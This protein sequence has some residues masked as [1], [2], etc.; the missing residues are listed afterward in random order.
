[1]KIKK[2]AVKIILILIPILCILLPSEVS[3]MS[4]EEAGTY[5]AR[6]A[7]N[8]YND[9]GELVNYEVDYTKR[10]YC[11]NTGKPWEATGTY[12]IDCVGFVALVIKQSIHLQSDDGTVENGGNGYVVPTQWASDTQFEVV[13][14][15]KPGDI[16]AN[17]HHVMIYVGGG[18]IV[19]CDGG[20][21]KDRPPRSIKRR[22]II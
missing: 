20:H 11:V 10:N 14:D 15:L 22:F 6:Y 13:Y 5:I 19:H 4:Q 21:G 2:I 9:K 1:M 16:L 12:D 8:F 18:M 7:M 3:A 17:Y